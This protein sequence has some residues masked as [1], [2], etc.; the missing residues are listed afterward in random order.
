MSRQSLDPVDEYAKTF[1]LGERAC[2]PVG[3][4]L[5]VD[6]SLGMGHESEHPAGGIA[7]PGNVAV[8][9]V[10]IFGISRLATAGRHV[11]QSYQP[12]GGQ[13]RE[14][15]GRRRDEPSF[16]VTDGQVHLAEPLRPHTAR[17]LLEPD[18]HPS[19]LISARVVVDERHLLAGLP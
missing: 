14:N 13:L 15:L 9:P 2:G 6:E 8:G 18:P 5:G 12:A 3:V 17:A 7:D 16:A 1:P 11:P 10:G 19:V 4:I